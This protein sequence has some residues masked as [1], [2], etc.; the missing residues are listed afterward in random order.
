MSIAEPR[1]GY[2]WGT[3][4]HRPSRNRAFL[5]GPVGY[6]GGVLRRVSLAYVVLFGRGWY[7][8]T[9][10]EHVER[11][12]FDVP[13][14]ELATLWRRKGKQRGP[15][16]E[17]M[18]SVATLREIVRLVASFSPPARN[19]LRIALPERSCWPYGYFG[20]QQL[21]TLIELEAI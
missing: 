9:P 12:V 3:S 11:E 5:R 14:N 17:E 10:N 21:A 19:S 4:C 18:L 20:K 1:L 16:S 7:K 6:G 2:S 15:G 8:M 13:W